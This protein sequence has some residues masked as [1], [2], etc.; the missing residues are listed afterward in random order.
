MA[1]KKRHKVSVIDKRQTPSSIESCGYLGEH[2]C[3][4]LMFSIGLGTRVN[5]L[6]IL[7]KVSD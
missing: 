7:F 2:L 5:P 1:G 6:S 3:K 4:V